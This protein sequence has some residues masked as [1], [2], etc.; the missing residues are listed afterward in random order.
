M[1]PGL[2]SAAILV[3]ALTKTMTGMCANGAEP[4]FPERPLRIIQ[5]FS[6]GGISDT[7]ARVVGDKLGRRLGQVVVVEAR[8]GA[9]G[10]VSMRAVLDATPDGYTLLLGNSAI[11]VSPNRRDRP[12]FDPM[13]VFVPVSMIGTAPSI[14]LSNPSAPVTSMRELIEYAKVHPGDVDCATSGIGTTNDLGV[15]LLNFMAGV[16]ILNVPYKGSGPSLNAVL[17]DETP[18][19]FAPLLPSIPHVRTG[20]LRGIAVSSLKRNPALPDVPSVAETLP[21]YEDVGFY[22]IVAQHEVP[23]PIIELVHREIN[24]VLAMPDVRTQL[25]NFGLDVNVMTRKEFADF[26]RNDAEKWA[27]LVRKGHLVL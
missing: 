19:S 22:G 8:P 13:K 23:M 15:H 18:L 5:G 12:P 24:E 9:G 7:L 16:R 11:T 25:E 26:M 21:G 1:K 6:V 14:I 10:L 20:R 27:G 2:A 3:L 4:A 17:S